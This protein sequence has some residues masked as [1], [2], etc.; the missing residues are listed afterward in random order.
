[1]PD[2]SCRQLGGRVCNKHETAWQLPVAD[3]LASATKG[4]VQEIARVLDPSAKFS[5]AKPTPA[6]R[7]RQQPRRAGVFAVLH[8]DR[9]TM[10]IDLDS[11]GPTSR[12][13]FS[14]R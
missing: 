13:Y 9:Q 1:M 14:Q 8:R 3:R 7:P 12:I 4:Q 2:L 6:S 5:F 10:A 11:S